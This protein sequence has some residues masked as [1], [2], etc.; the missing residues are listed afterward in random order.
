MLRGLRSQHF[1]IIIII[2]TE[3][4][5]LCRSLLRRQSSG[6]LSLKRDTFID[7]IFFSCRIL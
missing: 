1:I 4:Y 3:G 2:A 6:R 7:N 5:R